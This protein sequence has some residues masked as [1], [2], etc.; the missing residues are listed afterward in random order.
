[1]P[2][3]GAGGNA[4]GAAG[5]GDAG[6]NGT[7]FCGCGD[8]THMGLGGRDGLAGWAGGIVGAG[9]GN[10]GRGGD[11][12]ATLG[13]AGT[14]SGTG[15]RGSG[16]GAGGGGYG[17]GSGGSAGS[18]GGAG[19]SV[20]PA[21]STISRAPANGN[22]SVV[23]SYA[24]IPGTYVAPPPAIP[25]STQTTTQTTVTTTQPTPYVS[26]E[27]ARS[28]VE[29]VAARTNGFRRSATG[30]CSQ[31]S[32]TRV[33]CWIVAIRRGWPQRRVTVTYATPTTVKYQIRQSMRSR[34]A[35]VGALCTDGWQSSATSSGACAHHK[36]VATWVFA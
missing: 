16:G 12:D 10:G 26:I 19:G 22:G 9:N 25:A 36:G 32:E 7:Y 4:G 27:A 35:R 23:F 28:A 2:Q 5:A 31:I 1:M 13:G 30:W 11:S 15:G 33:D 20:G 3:Y 34:F 6:A 29:N 21:G 8:T 14:G 18:G 24:T 17:G